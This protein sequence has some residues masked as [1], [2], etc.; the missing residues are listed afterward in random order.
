M[1]LR[2][3]LLSF[4]LLAAIFGWARSKKVAD[5]PDEA[6]LVQLKKAGSN[7]SKPY[8]IEFFVYFPDESRAR[9]AEVK[10]KELGFQ[11]DVRSAAQG[12]DWLCFS[13]KTMVPELSELQK[14]RRNL[15]TIAKSLGG[16]YDGWGTGVVK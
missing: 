8:E 13:T 3:R 12:S 10:L 6:V 1:V 9:Q 11:V 15:T 4:S 14:S 16:E 2:T 7:P 5:D